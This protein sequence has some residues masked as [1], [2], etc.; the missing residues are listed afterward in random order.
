MLMDLNSTYKYK[1]IYEKQKEIGAL[2]FLRESGIAKFALK[3]KSKYYLKTKQSSRQ[4]AK[5][6]FVTCKQQRK[7]NR[8]LFNFF[9]I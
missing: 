8:F 4:P 9:Y 1:C 6:Y 5:K 2:G 7:K 3:N